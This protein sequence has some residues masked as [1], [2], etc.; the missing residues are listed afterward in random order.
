M[1]KIKQKKLTGV[2]DRLEENKALFKKYL[3]RHNWT[4]ADIND[5]QWFNNKHGT[6]FYGKQTD[7]LLKNTNGICIYTSGNVWI[8]YWDNKGDLTR[9]W[10]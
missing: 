2:A 10:I 5:Y 8:G 1:A 9:P 6:T 7:K 3:I 4:H